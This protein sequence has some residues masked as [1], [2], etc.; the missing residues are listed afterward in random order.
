MDAQTR[1]CGVRLLGR[2]RGRPGTAGSWTPSWMASDLSDLSRDGLFFRGSWRCRWCCG[3]LRSGP[4]HRAVDGLGT[5]EGTPGLREAREALRV[6]PGSCRGIS[7]E[8]VSRRLIKRNEKSR[9]A[10]KDTLKKN[11][12]ALTPG[13]ASLDVS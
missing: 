12:I 4:A 11:S 1:W 2:L 9:F 8:S 3:G 13:L 7:D 6:D 10:R 5:R